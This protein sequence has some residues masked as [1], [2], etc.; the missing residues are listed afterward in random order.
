MTTPTIIHMGSGHG[1][2]IGRVASKH[3]E[4][5]REKWV[6]EWEGC[7]DTSSVSTSEALKAHRNWKK[8]HEKQ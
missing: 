4:D 7:D 3:I 5:G 1:F 8:H 6:L 2:W